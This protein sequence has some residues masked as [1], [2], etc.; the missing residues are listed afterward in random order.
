MIDSLKREGLFDEAT[1]LIHGDHGSSAYVYA[2]MVANMDKLS[3][4][5]LREA[6]STLFAMKRPQ[7]EFRLH[8]DSRALDELM[9][10]AATAMGADGLAPPEPAPPT[11]TLFL[12]DFPRLFQ[13]S[14][15]MFEDVPPREQDGQNE[16]PD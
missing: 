16:S 6:Y 1:I 4:R 9:G 15:D 7:G 13:V 12:S 2:P 5:D 14:I 11:Q 3:R 8:P 10:I